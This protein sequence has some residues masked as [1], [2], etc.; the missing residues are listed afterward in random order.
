MQRFFL[1]LHATVPAALVVAVFVHLWGPSG[2]PSLAQR[3]VW[4]VWA[5]IGTWLLMSAAAAWALRTLALWRVALGS[6]G[7]LLG[8]AGIAGL[9]LGSALAPA[10][11]VSLAGVGAACAG[12]AAFIGPQ[13]V[14]APRRKAGPA[15]LR[16]SSNPRR[17]WRRAAAQAAHLPFWL[18]G[19]LAVESFRLAHVV[20]T[21]PARSSGMLGLLLAFFVAL[22]AATLRHWAPRVA[23]ALWWLAA[24]VYGGQAV[25]AGLWQWRVAAVLCALAATVP[26]WIQLQR[27]TRWAARHHSAPPA[28]PPRSEAA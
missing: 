1:A 2:M 16:H 24:A 15:P 12:M 14:H 9:A 17:R 5:L 25:Q 10:M 6:T 13:R 22:P 18:C 23:A 27:R 8:A 7:V 21:E 28:Q 26:A 3:P 11:L 4:A 19:L 20:A